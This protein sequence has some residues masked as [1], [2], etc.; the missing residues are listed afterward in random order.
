MGTF[1]HPE[2]GNIPVIKTKGIFYFRPKDL[3]K[4][5]HI[6]KWTY[7][8]AVA[9]DDLRPM[10]LRWRQREVWNEPMVPHTVVLEKLIP[11]AE[12]RIAYSFENWLKDT[13]LPSQCEEVKTSEQSDK[14]LGFLTS[15]FKQ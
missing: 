10:P 13:V 5:L 2:C 6:N 8:K 12:E 4:C 1:K 9:Q 14:Q 11:A 3:I 15:C 7:N